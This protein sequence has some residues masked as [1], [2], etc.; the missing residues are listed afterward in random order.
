MAEYPLLCI[1]W[2]KPASNFL[3][4]KNLRLWING[5]LVSLVDKVPVYRVW[6][7]GSIPDQTNTHGLKIIEEK[8]LPLL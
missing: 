3:Q 4:K 2:F 8:M 6:G 7:S 1:F 5:R